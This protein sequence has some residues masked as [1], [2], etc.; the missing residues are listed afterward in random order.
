MIGRLYIW[1]CNKT[2][3]KKK[4]KK[5][6]W[7][8]LVLQ[9]HREMFLTQPELFCPQLSGA[10]SGHLFLIVSRHVSGNMIISGLTAIFT[11]EKKRQLIDGQ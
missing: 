4:K 6:T 3:K 8:E 7:K 1:Y 10:W 2:K 9:P 5:G 11:K